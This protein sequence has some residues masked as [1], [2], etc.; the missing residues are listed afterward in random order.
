MTWLSHR[1][2]SVAEPEAAI[3][4]SSL[5]IPSARTTSEVTVASVCCVTAVPFYLLWQSVCLSP[6][7]QDIVNSRWVLLHSLYKIKA[8]ERLSDL[9]KIPESANG[10]FWVEI[11]TRW[12][13]SRCFLVILRFHSIPFWSG[14]RAKSWVCVYTLTCPARL[15]EGEMRQGLW[16]RTLR[17]P[18]SFVLFCL[19]SQSCL[20]PSREEEPGLNCCCL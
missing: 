10:Q 7:H 5:E 19:I 15:A 14:D 2:W 20:E 4:T 11:H 1:S 17:L 18:W 6:R 8:P 13:Q 9:L 16:R 12:F 3:L